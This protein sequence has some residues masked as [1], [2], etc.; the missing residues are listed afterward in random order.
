VNLHSKMNERTVVTVTV[1]LN[2]SARDV[3]VQ[4]DDLQ[5]ERGQP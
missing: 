5:H 3:T 4:T 1:P 2:L